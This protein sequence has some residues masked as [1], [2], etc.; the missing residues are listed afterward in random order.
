MNLKLEIRYTKSTAYF[1]RTTHP[2]AYSG[3]EYIYS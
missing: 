3:N 1:T 2:N